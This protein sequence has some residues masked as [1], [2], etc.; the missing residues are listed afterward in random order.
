MHVARLMAPCWYLVSGIRWY[1]LYLGIL[2][3]PLCLWNR[4]DGAVASVKL[5]RC[6]GA[7]LS[8]ADT[9]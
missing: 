9:T 3:N 5:V 1:S 7:Q 2:G 4:Q 6:F 8:T